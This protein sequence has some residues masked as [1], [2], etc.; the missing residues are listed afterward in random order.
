M[1]REKDKIETTATASTVR[2]LVAAEEVVHR[3]LGVLV[4]G[5]EVFETGSC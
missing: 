1:E 3:Q 4:L 5:R 2:L